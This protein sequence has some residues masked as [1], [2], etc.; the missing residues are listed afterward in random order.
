M[1]TWLPKET[2]R[3]RRHSPPD[4]NAR[5]DAILA[6]RVDRYS[7]AGPVEIGRRIEALDRE[8]D[9]ERVLEANAASLSL[10]GLL[11]ARFQDRRWL[12]LPAGVAG[13]L[14]QHALQGWCPPIPVFRRLGVR[15]RREIDR[16][17]YALMALR[18][19]F[20]PVGTAASSAEAVRAALRAVRP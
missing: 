12:W 5:L 14:L 17:K 20:E 7:R 16:E 19:D 4:A 3:V 11:L 13:F 18:G 9:I 10:A 2:D 15:T 1:S 6:R 8:W